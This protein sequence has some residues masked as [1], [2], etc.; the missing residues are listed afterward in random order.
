[1][2]EMEALATLLR[3]LREIRSPASL[4]TL[5]QDPL[6]VVEKLREQFTTRTGRISDGGTPAD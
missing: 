2:D 1:M 5:K 4:E 3:Q 6:K